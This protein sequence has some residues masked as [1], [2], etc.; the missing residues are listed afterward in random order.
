MNSSMMLRRLFCFNAASTPAA[1]SVST[2]KKKPL[3]FL[4]SP[5][6]LSEFRH[7]GGLVIVSP[8]CL[9]TFKRGFRG[10]FFFH[11][12]FPTWALSCGAKKMWLNVTVQVTAIVTQPPTRRDRSRKV[13]PSPV[14][15]YALDRGFPSDLIFTPEHAGEHSATLY[16]DFLEIKFLN[17]PSLGTV[18][19]H[20]NLLPL[21]RG[22]APVQRALQDGV[23]ETGVSLALTVHALDAGPVFASERIEVDD[24]IKAGD[25][26]A[27]LFSEGSKLLI[28]ELPCIFDGST[29]EKQNLKM[30]LK[31]H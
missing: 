25:L 2:S 5:Q 6:L 31:L 15:Q 19:I 23:K 3:V 21:Y 7:I 28:R 20:P 27:M 17:I 1:S 12:N 14:A 8:S 4:G 13:M 26:L 24:Q 22:A 18:N 16:L 10:T 9:L 29:R 11:M 30:I